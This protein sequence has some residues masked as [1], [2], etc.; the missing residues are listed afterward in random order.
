MR[1]STS[2]ILFAILTCS[3]LLMSFQEKPT[4]AA[5]I[6]K[7][8]EEAVETRVKKYRT[9]R[10]KRCTEKILEEAAKQADS[11]IIARAKGLKVLQDTMD[12]PL[13]PGRPDRPDLLTPIDSSFPTPLLEGDVLEE[14]GDSIKR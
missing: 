11:I 1:K 13:A 6:Q 8:M 9:T 4:K 7:L 10:E 14:L 3:G 12:R 5:I 2:I